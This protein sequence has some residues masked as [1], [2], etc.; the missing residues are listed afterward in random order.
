MK[1]VDH[2]LRT[3]AKTE[4]W[5]NLE[6][7]ILLLS[8]YPARSKALQETLSEY[9]LGVL[10]HVGDEH[11]ARLPARFWFEFAKRV[12][13]HGSP[14]LVD[15]AH[16]VTQKVLFASG[17]SLNWAGKAHFLLADCLLGLRGDEV[18]ALLERHVAGS[19]HSAPS[20]QLAEVCF[21]FAEVRSQARASS[22]E[23]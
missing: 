10:R 4:S 21:D 3:L 8:V 16:E 1:Q 20:S 9:F 2:M 13:G 18:S 15:E 23:R 11:A 17:E 6:A 22:L 5:E 19:V 7:V 12:A 14:E